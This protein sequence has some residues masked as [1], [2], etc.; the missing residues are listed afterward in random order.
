MS[1]E[2]LAILMFVIFLGLLLAGYTVAFSFAGTAIVFSIL[3]ILLDVFP[4]V[5][6]NLLFNRW[7]SDGLANFVLVAIPFF[8]FM[9]AVFEK[10]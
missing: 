4:L 6:L 3:G 8:V 9:G 7:F 2:W 10:S 5:N 1:L